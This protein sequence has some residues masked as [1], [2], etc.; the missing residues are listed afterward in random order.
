MLR[1][2]TT[3]NI[4]ISTLLPPHALA[5]IA[6]LLDRATHFHATRL[7]CSLQAQT[8][9]TCGQICEWLLCAG[10]AQ[11]WAEERVAGACWGVDVAGARGEAGGW[12][13]GAAQREEEGSWEHFGWVALR[14]SWWG[15]IVVVRS[16]IGDADS[17][18]ELCA[19]ECTGVVVPALSCSCTCRS[20]DLCVIFHY[21]RMRNGMLV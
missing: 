8:V 7:R 15:G 1:I 21:G 11:T 6:H 9:K 10:G 2:L 20:L 19:K 14:G 5:P 17:E 3:N 4:H 13:E 12:E 18:V 16:W